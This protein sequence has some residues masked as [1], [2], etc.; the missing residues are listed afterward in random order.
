MLSN[1]TAPVMPLTGP[2]RSVR[3]WQRRG[4]KPPRQCSRCFEHQRGAEL[5]FSSRVNESE[6]LINLVMHDE[7]KMLISSNQKVRGQV[8]RVNCSLTWWLFHRRKRPHLTDSGTQAQRGK[9]VT[10]PMRQSEPQGQPMEWQV[11]ESRKSKRPAVMV[12]IEVEPLGNITSRASGQTSALVSLGEKG[13][14]STAAGKANVGRRNS[15]LC[16][17]HREGVDIKTIARR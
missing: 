14:E 4:A 8:Q 3:R 6:L 9:P 16:A 10:L 15:S 5:G 2:Y 13:D 11:G 7:L 12:G 17:L 1:M